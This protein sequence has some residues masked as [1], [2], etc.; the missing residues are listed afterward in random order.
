MV[1]WLKQYLIKSNAG[2]LFMF[3]TLDRNKPAE[4]ANGSKMILIH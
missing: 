2:K 3:S 4:S 1:L